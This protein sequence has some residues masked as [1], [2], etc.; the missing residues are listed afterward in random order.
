MLLKNV[1]LKYPATKNL[2]SA[3]DMS[4]ELEIEMQEA[5]IAKNRAVNQPI[6]ETDITTTHNLQ[7]TENIINWI[8]NKDNCNKSFELSSIVQEQLQQYNINL[9]LKKL[10]KE[11]TTLSNNDQDNFDNVIYTNERYIH[12][13]NI[14]TKKQNNK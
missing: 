11:L 1:N 6:S 13:R 7:K 4:I 9:E 14:Q 2:N 12:W 3:M 8:G 10:R 5:F